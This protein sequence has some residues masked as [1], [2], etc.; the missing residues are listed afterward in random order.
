MFQL[1]LTRVFIFILL[2]ASVQA[3][4]TGHPSAICGGVLTSVEKLETEIAEG[5]S[6]QGVEVYTAESNALAKYGK[7]FDS[8][9]EKDARLAHEKLGEYIKRSESGE[10]ATSAIAI[11]GYEARAFLESADLGAKQIVGKAKESKFMKP[12]ATLFMAPRSLI[13]AA[14]AYKFLNKKESTLNTL[15]ALE[16]GFC[17]VSFSR[18]LVRFIRDLK[19]SGLEKFI[20]T[21]LPRLEQAATRNLSVNILSVK[22]ERSL[23]AIK[24]SGDGNQIASYSQQVINSHMPLIAPNIVRLFK[25]K[26]FVFPTTSVQVDLIAMPMG[27]AGERGLLVLSSEAL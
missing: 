1:K 10:F 5:M 25:K 15:M 3:G 27:L 2:S 17:T 4:M 8:F 23:D 6:K 11:H 20:M 19:K 9:P 12:L 24:V 22:A 14:G 21:E 7:L 26:S 16:M 13:C 18:P